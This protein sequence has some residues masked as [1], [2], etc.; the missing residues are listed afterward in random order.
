MDDWRCRTSAK[1]SILNLLDLQ[2]KQDN[3]DEAHSSNQT[4]LLTAKQAMPSQDQADATD[5]QSQILFIFTFV[6]IFFLALSFFTSYYGMNVEDFHGNQMLRKTSYVWK[7]MGGSS[8]PIITS[9]LLG[10]VVWY[11]WSKNKAKKE[12]IE[13]LAELMKNGA[14][15]S[16]LFKEDDSVYQE[17]KQKAKGIREAE[18]AKK[19][20][21]EGVARRRGATETV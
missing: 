9:L 10:G 5:A 13:D 21:E 7:I 6:T 3:I 8:F 15:P 17:I 20:E 4:A 18:D 2:Q 19:R 14:L 1:E 11:V 12:R 16:G